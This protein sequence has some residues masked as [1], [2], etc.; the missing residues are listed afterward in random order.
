M[1]L[2]PLEHRVERGPADLREPSDLR[3]GEPGRERLGRESGDCGALSGLRGHGVGASLAV[4]GEGRADLVGFHGPSVNHLTTR[5]LIRKV[6]YMSKTAFPILSDSVRN[7]RRADGRMTGGDAVFLDGT[8]VFVGK[9]GECVTWAEA[10]VKG[11]NWVVRDARKVFTN[12]E[13]K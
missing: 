4:G 13:A 9:F 7:Q 2:L 5:A 3:L 12:P 10:N 8:P 1:V 6:L 11:Q